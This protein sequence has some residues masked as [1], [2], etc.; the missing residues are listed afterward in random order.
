MSDFDAVEILVK[1]KNQASDEL[2]K[3][4]RKFKELRKHSNISSRISVN[5]YG[6]I[7]RT[8]QSLRY[9]SRDRYADLWIRK[10]VYGLDKDQLTRAFEGTRLPDVDLGGQFNLPDNSA[11]LMGGLHG[12]D[13][14][15]RRMLKAMGNPM[16]GMGRPGKHLQSKSKLTLRLSK[17][18][19]K[20]GRASRLARFGV[21][22]MGGAV[23]KMVPTYHMIIAVVSAMIPLLVTLAVQA[24]GVA[25][26]FGAVAGAGAAMFGLGLLGQGATLNQSLA[27]S[28]QLLSEF[29]QEMYETFRPAAQ[30][31][32]PFTEDIL[33]NGAVEFEPLA[34]AAANLVVF[35]DSAR[36]AFR[37]LIEW[38]AQGITVMSQYEPM[39]EQLTDRFGGPLG[40]AIINFFRFVTEE[41][42][43]NQDMLM[44]LGGT[45]IVIL[46]TIYNLSLAFSKM[47]VALTPLLRFVA[48]IADLLANDWVAGA[49][50]AAV[51]IYAIATAAMTLIGVLQA[52]ATM[53]ALVHGLYGNFGLIAL[54]LSA[55]A[56]TYAVTETMIPK[57]RSTKYN[58]SISPAGG[59]VNNYNFVVEGDV[60]DKHMREMESTFNR[61]YDEEQ[62]ARSGMS[63]GPV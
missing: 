34:D 25:T 59:T 52:V 58:D 5:D 37:G 7:E 44:S 45:F 38:A 23:R 31:M 39:L 13:I 62:S 41:A 18:F 49:A 47:V 19:R 57:G 46:H 6:A 11:D 60:S 42:Y 51:G 35:Q 28:K 21:A 36:S 2:D 8:E 40:T 10:H 48:L 26:A 16:F 50:A 43:K 56:A 1:I 53:L 27:R 14:N 3:I 12:F 4:D 32:A 15:R 55:A 22:G 20:L 63:P 9:L 17:A 24:M 30:L 61:R 33:R 54:G 29:K